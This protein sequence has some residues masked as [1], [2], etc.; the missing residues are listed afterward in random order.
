MSSAQHRTIDALGGAAMTAKG[1]RHGK[2]AKGHELVL[3]QS[4]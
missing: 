2:N 4:S 3:G 1:V